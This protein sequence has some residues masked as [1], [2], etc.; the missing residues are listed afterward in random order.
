MKKIITYAFIISTLISVAQQNI[1]GK[2]TDAKDLPI[3]GANVYLE[4]TYDGATTDETGSFLFSTDEIG[5]KKLIISYLSYETKHIESDVKS[6][7]S[8]EIKLRDNV[9][10]KTTSMHLKNF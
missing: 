10:E 9:D 6:L 4:G 7:T 2:V 8:L 3:V 5:T 1:N